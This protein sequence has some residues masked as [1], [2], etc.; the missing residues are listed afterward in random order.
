MEFALVGTLLLLMLLFVTDLGLQLFTQSAMDQA[1]V[2]AAHN[3][4]TGYGNYPAGT[5]IGTNRGSA[6]DVVNYVCP[7]LPVPQASCISGGL[8]VYA[9]TGTTFAA[10]QR[11]DSPGAGLSSTAFSA[12][13]S[14]APVIL[15]VAYHRSSVVPFGS[16]IVF[17]SFVE[18]WVISTIVFENEQ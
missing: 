10:L 17:T 4:Q 5:Q 11:K 16:N 3:I 7:I 2:R 6:Q 15:Q 12:G 18:P 1:T 13:G 14:A 9:A 8:K